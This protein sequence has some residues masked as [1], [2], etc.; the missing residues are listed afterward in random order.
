[1]NHIFTVIAAQATVLR[2]IIYST[3]CSAGIL[4]TMAGYAWGFD[5]YYLLKEGD[6]ALDQGRS[7][8]A[9][10]LF[11]KYIDTHPATQGTKSTRYQK[12]K[13]YYI[14]NLLTA[15][16]DLFEVF[17]ETGNEAEF[18]RR[19][20]M[21]KATF[22]NGGFS[23]KNMYNLAEIYLDFN[24]DEDAR[25]ILELIVTEHAI[26]HYPYNIKVTL[27]AYSKLFNILKTKGDNLAVE[28]LLTSLADNYPDP[29]FDSN[30][31]YKLALLYFT[32]GRD[33]Q[34]LELLNAIAAE[35]Q[36]TSSSPFIHT[37][38]N[39][40][41]KLLKTSHK[42][43]DKAA[44]KKIM[45]T[46]AGEGFE[47]L[48]AGNAYKLAVAFLNS[49]EKETGRK[50]FD[51]LSANFPETV[52]GRKSLFLRARDA[53]SSKDWDTAI[54]KYSKYID[55]YPDKHFFALKAYSSLLDAH[56][57]RDGNLED[58]EI[59]ISLFADIINQVTDYETQLNLARDLH[60]KGFGELADATF[61]LG[62]AAANKEIEKE[63]LTLTAMRANWLIAKYA[64]EL[65]KFDIA[66]QRGSSV[67]AQS[68]NSRT[69]LRSKKEKER[70][71]H[72]LSRTY[73]NLAE[74][75]EAAEDYENAEEMLNRFVEEFADD[76]DADYARY[77]L[78]RL[79][80]K[81]NKKS[82]AAETYRKVRGGKW[83]EN[84]AKRLLDIGGL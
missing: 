18:N 10:A 63:P 4:V 48:S 22:N 9:Q 43:G 23:H 26:S 33:E 34:G 83:K 17:R 40:Y 20:A 77:K 78:G 2:K 7:A 28:K 51:T 29:E 13:Q 58:Q 65:G 42:K 70:E 71:D 53:M 21:L 16:S 6:I 54:N 30:D 73:L 60:R 59:K 37:L 76:V 47:K 8:E 64:V 35:E 24:R 36:F 31:K 69:W 82:E 32:N 75:N 45:T 19:L 68:N 46:L 79:Y 56:W 14:K 84:A 27:R 49:G 15:Y 61:T 44:S 67:I 12:K 3:F 50:I 66:R 80:E 38:I 57:S 25:P 52:W 41:I 5:G 1:M 72:F 81:I 74:I 11:E 55:R 62:V 39:T